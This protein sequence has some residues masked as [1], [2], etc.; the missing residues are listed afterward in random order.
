ML[1]IS[2]VVPWTVW[3]GQA[4]TARV[5]RAVEGDTLQVDAGDR[6]ELVRLIGV[7]AP[8]AQDARTSGQSFKQEAQA[9]TQH[10]LAGGARSA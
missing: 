8:M 5:V 4:D 1:A 6:R 7:D 9:F 3:T 2:L 10:L